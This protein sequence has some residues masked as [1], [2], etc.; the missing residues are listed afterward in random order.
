M[1]PGMSWGGCTRRH[2]NSNVIM[3]HFQT[4][5]NHEALASMVAMPIMIPSSSTE[6]A[7]GSASRPVRQRLVVYEGSSGPRE[8]MESLVIQATAAIKG[9]E[10][11]S[12][13]K[14]KD[15]QEMTEAQKRV[16]T[17]SV[18]PGNGKGKGKEKAM[19]EDNAKLLQ[20]W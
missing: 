8:L 15:N 10:G 14:D 4:V 6:V 3:E 17:A 16:L 12:A 5:S 20:F 1:A 7:G 2:L 13:G 9:L 19:N 11:T 18:G